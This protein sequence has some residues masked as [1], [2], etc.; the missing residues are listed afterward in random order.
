VTHTTTQ[1]AGQLTPDISGPVV[2]DLWIEPTAVYDVEVVVTINNSGS[3]AVTIDG[4]GSPAPRVTKRFL[5]YFSYKSGSYGSEGGPPLRSFS[6]A[7][8][9]SKVVV[10]DYTQVC[11][12]S[13][14]CFL[15]ELHPDAGDLLVLGLSLPHWS[16]PKTYVMKRRSS[17]SPTGCALA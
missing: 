17:G 8:R 11:T 5:S 6:L 4:L 14:R 10:V 9:S 2:E 3:Q 1:I 15:F 12:P 13:S 7:G 16:S